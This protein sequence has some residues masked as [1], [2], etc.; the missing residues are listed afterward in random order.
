MNC[1]Y[2]ASVALA[3]NMAAPVPHLISFKVGNVIETVGWLRLLSPFWHSTRIA[4]I[5]METIVNMSPEVIG[6]MK[7]RA[8]AN[9]N[10]A[11]K[12]FWAI[13]AVRSTSIGRHVVV[14][15]GTVGSRS[16][17]NSDLSLYFRGHNRQADHGNRNQ[18]QKSKTTHI[19][20]LA[21]N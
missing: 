18:Q 3:S 15:V 8:S 21:D 9:E 17:L 6:A 13:I 11:G 16:D 19:F 4:V 7:P 20:H 10:A 14:T 2:Q 1:A 12:P 5:R